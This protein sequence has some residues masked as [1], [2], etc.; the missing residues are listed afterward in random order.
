MENNNG[1]KGFF[2]LLIKGEFGL[3]RTYWLFGV[4]LGLVAII[5]MA[6]MPSMPFVTLFA[7]IYGLFAAVVLVGIWRAGSAYQGPVI[8]PL[9]ARLTGVA[10]FVALFFLWFGMIRFVVGF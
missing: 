3:A 5:A 1:K 7:T 6:S 9:L 8:W 4:A 10:G 2:A